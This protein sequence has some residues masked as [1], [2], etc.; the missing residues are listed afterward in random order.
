MATAMM[1]T[2]NSLKVQYPKRHDLCTSTTFPEREKRTKEEKDI[3]IHK[4]VPN[5]YQECIDSMTAWHLVRSL[6]CGGLSLFL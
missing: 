2:M 1:H 5:P 3:I 6:D 4:P